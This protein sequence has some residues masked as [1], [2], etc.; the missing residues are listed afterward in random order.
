MMD[1]NRLW[2][3]TNRNGHEVLQLTLNNAEAM[4]LPQGPLGLV[5]MSV[6]GVP[7][8]ATLGLLD[9][10]EKLQYRYQVDRKR[11]Q[12]HAW[13]DVRHDLPMERWWQY[14]VEHSDPLLWYVSFAPVYVEYHPSKHRPILYKDLG[15]NRSE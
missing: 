13:R 5:W 3:F 15:A 6:I 10:P 12:V 9:Y 1:D 11:S 4:L 2:H 7:V 14:E 8:A